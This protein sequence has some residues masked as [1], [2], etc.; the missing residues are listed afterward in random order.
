VVLAFFKNPIFRVFLD[1]G[2]VLRTKTFNKCFIIFSLRLPDFV[3]LCKKVEKDTSESQFFFLL[4]WDDMGSKIQNFML[5]YDL[6]EYFRK[7]APERKL[8]QTTIVF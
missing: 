3:F 8:D 6:K 4:K 1:S 5:I 2:S 7:C